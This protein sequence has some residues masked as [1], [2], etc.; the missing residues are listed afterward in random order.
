M[1]RGASLPSGSPLHADGRPG[2]QVRRLRLLIIGPIMPPKGGVS[3]HIERLAKLLGSDFA[4]SFLDE[5]RNLKKGV[6][7]LRHMAPMTYL[8]MIAHADVVH[9]H[10][11]SSVL[12]FMHVLCARLLLK[13]VVLTV[14]SVRGMGL[15]ARIARAASARLSHTVVA[16]SDRVGE[17]IGGGT[18]RVIPA[19]IPPSQ[20]EFTVSSEVA[21]WIAERKSEG[22]FVF[23]SNA[24]RLERFQGGDLYGLD[25]IIDAFTHPSVARLCACVFVV[26]APDFD[27]HWLATYKERVSQMQTQGNFLLHTHSENFAG[28]AALAD[29]TIRATCS[30]GDALSV[31][32]SLYLGKVTLASDAAARPEGT[33]IFKSRDVQDLVKTIVE[34]LAEK[35]V[36]QPAAASMNKYRDLYVSLYSDRPGFAR[37]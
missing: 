28:I 23:A 6:P 27:P 12:K 3:V 1:R 14:H 30:D 10:S 15:L 17:S 20:S 8:S 7:N 25:L 35:S 32:E 13:R 9:V 24:Y 34:S 33:K 31:R 22:R 11:F 26:G 19:F 4:I 5:S 29:G 2:Q 16:V 37:G 21:Q 36:D 18:P